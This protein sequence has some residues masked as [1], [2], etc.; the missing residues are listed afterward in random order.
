MSEVDDTVVQ[1]MTAGWDSLCPDMMG[2][3]FAALSLLDLGRAAPTCR[4]FRAAFKARLSAAHPAAVEA[5]VSLFGEAFL[6]AHSTLLLRMSTGLDLL[7][8]AEF[9]CRQSRR[10]HILPDGTYQLSYDHP[11]GG[12]R[13][14]SCVAQVGR[15]D[16]R[17]V[18]A[19]CF[20]AMPCSDTLGV[21]YRHPNPYFALACKVGV[22]YVCICVAC[23]MAYCGQ[24]VGAVAAICGEY[25]RESG[26]WSGAQ[27]VAVQFVF[28]RRPL[29]HSALPTAAQLDEIAAA[30]LPLSRMFRAMAFFLVTPGQT[31]IAHG[32]LGKL[33]T[34]CREI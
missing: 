20:S 8:G 25:L 21:P 34:V 4:G 30:M 2:Q 29:P 15:C 14:T 17:V 26:T 16:N 9:S 13:P 11:G 19:Q 31:A 12:A 3:I 10:F 6:R 23:E 5:G 22:G 32:N 33:E 1:A 28:K 27:E 7:S 24:T 18:H